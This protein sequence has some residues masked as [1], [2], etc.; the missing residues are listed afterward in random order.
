MSYVVTN[1]SKNPKINF[2]CIL[3]LL[4][5][6]LTYKNTFATIFLQLTLSIWFHFFQGWF[7]LIRCIIW[8]WDSFLTK[9]TI[10]IGKTI[11][12]SYRSNNSEDE[13]CIVKNMNLIDTYYHW[14]NLVDWISNMATSK[15]YSLRKTQKLKNINFTSHDYLPQFCSENRNWL[16]YKDGYIYLEN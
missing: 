6:S 12:F 4:L 16:S 13:K 8:W 5:G 14:K 7:G 11:F 15:M 1:C 9:V 10:E 2:W 3:T